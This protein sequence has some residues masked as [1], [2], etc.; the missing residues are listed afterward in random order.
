MCQFRATS[1]H[2]SRGTIGC[3]ARNSWGNVRKLPSGKFQARYCIDYVWHS[4]PAT[5]RT[6]KEADSFLAGVRADLDRGVWLD[7]GAGKVSV[8]DYSVRWLR[9][10]PQLRPR[11]VEL[12]EGLLRNHINPSLGATQ[13]NQLSSARVREW[14]ATM[15]RSGKPG[16]S[17]VAKCYR[18]LHAIFA[19]AVED[20]L[21]PRNPCII[22]G[23]SIERPAERPVASIAQVFEIADAIEPQYRAMVMLGT[24]CSLRLGEIRALRRRHIDLLHR[25]VRV[26]EQ[27][28]ELSNGELVVGPPKSDAGVR[29]VAIP[30]AI[31]PEIETHLASFVGVEADAMLFS[32]I[33]GAPLRR[34][35]FYT[36]WSRALKQVGISSLRFHDLRH[37]GNTLAAMTGASTKELMSRMGQSSP[38][39]ALIYQHA[40]QARDEAI[41]NGLS[42]LIEAQ[43]PDP[44]P[45]SPV[46]PIAQGASRTQRKTQ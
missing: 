27:I 39:A 21:V 35:T 25:T 46:T 2:I 17:A 14:R 6:K 32:N 3:M 8:A 10:R 23:A 28:Q 12:Y 33:N 11:T 44:T 7:P 4:A 16:V 30:A 20:G 36:V 13:M 43:R 15:L 38:R 41:A 34:A 45:P 29:T 26:E 24:F 22:K 9:E 18:L 31:L 40:T 5:F 42:S 1:C 37:T 19:T